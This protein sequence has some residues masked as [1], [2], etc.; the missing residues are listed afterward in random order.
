MNY[1][2]YNYY[3]IYINAYNFSIHMCVCMFM[4]IHTI[5]VVEQFYRL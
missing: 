1:I 5:D 4:H 2:Y 3:I